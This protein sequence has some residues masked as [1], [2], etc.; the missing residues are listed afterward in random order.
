[1]VAFR[2]R[3]AVAADVD[4][5]F[6]WVNRPDCL[7][8]KWRTTGPVPR[9]GHEA[10]FAARL[11]D[12]GT[13]IAIIEVDGQPAGQ[14][15]LQAGDDGAYAVDIYVLPE[16]RRGGVARTALRQA[17]L[18]LRRERPQA[19]VAA[20]VRAENQPSHRLFRALGFRPVDEAGGL[21]RY[22]LEEDP[23]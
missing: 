23:A 9:A 19:M 6:Q 8:G 2:L 17:I 16:Y 10:W 4:L 13:R 5:L 3:P 15:R 22:V 18:N 1:M 11:A 12:A 21:C 7:A 20:E 14:A